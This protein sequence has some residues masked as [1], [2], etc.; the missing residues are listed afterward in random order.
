MLK[1]G[2]RRSGH[3]SPSGKLNN[4][5]Q[6]GSIPFQRDETSWSEKISQSRPLSNRFRVEPQENRRELQAP[7][8]VCEP[9]LN[10][11]VGSGFPHRRRPTHEVDCP[12]RFPAQRQRIDLIDIMSEPADVAVIDLLDV[13]TCP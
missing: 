8:P 3:Y 7:A 13:S 1:T 5:S 12:R 9:A 4:R 6:C 2:T 11:C 10:D